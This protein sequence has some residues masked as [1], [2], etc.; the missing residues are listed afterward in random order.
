MGESVGSVR[1]ACKR[2]EHCGNSGNGERAGK[3][4]DGANVLQAQ[5]RADLAKMTDKMAQVSNM[6]TQ[7]ETL[8]QAHVAAEKAQ[9]ARPQSKRMAKGAFTL[10]AAERRFRKQTEHCMEQIRGGAEI[11][12]H[13]L[14]DFL[15]TVS[16]KEV[17]VVLKE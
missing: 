2:T 16:P 13:V 15:D 1:T 3:P 14:K 9:R 4:T 6:I 12:Y 5:L 8:L 7:Q 10:S 11:V 17:C